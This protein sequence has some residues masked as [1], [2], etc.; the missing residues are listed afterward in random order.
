MQK[1]INIRSSQGGLANK[2]ACYTTDGWRIVS[3]V[4]GSEWSRI[5]NT[6]KW[7]VILEKDEPAKQQQKAAPAAPAKKEIKPPVL[8]EK[9]EEPQLDESKALATELQRAKSLYDSG[10][11]TEEEYEKLKAK[12]LS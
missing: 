2:L 6:Y 11:I 12:I 4:R 3:A 7:T 10:V 9:K 1:I 5:F 8:E